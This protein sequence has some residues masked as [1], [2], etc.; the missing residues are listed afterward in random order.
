MPDRIVRY[1]IILPVGYT[2]SC[3]RVYN[4]G[5]DITILVNTTS[6][7]PDPTLLWVNCDDCDSTKVLLRYV[8]SSDAG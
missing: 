1:T 6:P 2:C 5:D 4:K 3:G 7:Q 8:D